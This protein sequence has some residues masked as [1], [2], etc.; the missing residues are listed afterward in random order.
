MIYLQFIRIGTC[1]NIPNFL[2]FRQS[3]NS[4]EQAYKRCSKIATPSVLTR[5]YTG[6]SNDK[7]GASRIGS[8]HPSPLPRAVVVINKV[9][10]RRAYCFS[11]TSRRRF[12]LDG[13]LSFLTRTANL[14]ERSG[15]A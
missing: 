13:S 2:L 8:R 7:F 14:R 1:N 3:A 10:D 15:R 4:H 6:A 12:G 11:G 5:Q 9:R